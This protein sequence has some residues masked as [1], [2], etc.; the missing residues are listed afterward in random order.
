MQRPT[1]GISE[2]LFSALLLCTL[3]LQV[4]AQNQTLEQRG[5][6]LARAADCGSCHTVPG[7]R[8][9][10]GGTPLKSA[11]GTIYGSNITPDPQTGI[12][13]WSKSDFER[14]LRRGQRKDGT[15]LYPAMPY[16]S[17]TKMTAADLDALWAY[18]RT[19]PPVKNQVPPTTLPFPLDLR[20]G[21]AVWQS[22]Y[23]KPGA[24]VPVAGKT[25]VWNRGAYLVEALGHCTDCHTP[26]NVAQSLEPQHQLTGAQ[27]E[28]WYATDISGDPLSAVSKRSS[29]ELEVFLKSGVL[30]DNTKAVG[31]MQEVVQD[32]LR[33]LTVADI[34]AMVVYLKDQPRN[35]G[36]EHPTAVKYERLAAGKTVYEDQCSSCHQSDGKGIGESVPALAGN[37][38]VTASEPYNVVMSILVGFPA[39]GAWGAMAS[40]A[41]VLS[42]D[43]IADVT[44]YVRTA[45]GNSAPPNATPWSVQTLRAN[46]PTPKNETH[47]LLCPDLNETAIKPALALGASMLKQAAADRQKMAQAVANYRAAVPTASTAQVLE[48]LSAAY[49]KAIADDP[50]SDAM[51]NTQIVN[52]AQQASLTLSRT[53]PS[54]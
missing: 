5:E 11:F 4:L 33:Y 54:T 35:A 47:A 44:N 53:K 32:S 25:A 42:D 17:Y 9:F 15:Y 34:R 27:I 16:D 20:Q 28:G 6:Y 2:S 1:R 8:P 13:S 49:C 18:V 43:Q 31:P 39:H 48:A 21:L 37:D 46:T 50:I 24:F 30:P 41:S 52:F 23:F 26:R 22:L 7:G 29:K 3:S 40:F 45:W 51:M 10:A 19:R 36:P 12:G 14:A 38:A